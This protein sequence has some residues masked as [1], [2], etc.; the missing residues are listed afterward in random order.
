MFTFKTGDYQDDGK[1]LKPSDNALDV[2]FVPM[3]QSGGRLVAA[4]STDVSD[5]FLE[6]AKH[7]TDNLDYY[8]QEPI[9]SLIFRYAQTASLLRGL[10]AENVDL[11][12][13]AHGIE[14]ATGE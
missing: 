4:M 8:G 3:A 14:F 2:L 7:I 9:V 12:Q 6:N 1:S 5:E 10:K 11:D 13:L